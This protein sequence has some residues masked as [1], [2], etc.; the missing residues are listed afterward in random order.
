MCYVIGI[1]LVGT[2]LSNHKHIEWQKA[3][4]NGGVLHNDIRKENILLN[5]HNYDTKK[6]WWLFDEEKRKLKSLLDHYT[7]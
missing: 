3:I 6:R 2:P 5:D 4:H 1:T 7:Y